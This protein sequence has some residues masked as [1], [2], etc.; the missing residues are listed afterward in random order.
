MTIT[1]RLRA[2]S[3]GAFALVAALPLASTPSRAA[4]HAD[5]PGTKADLAADITDIYAWADGNKVVASIGFAGLAEAGAPATYDPDVLYTIHV[6]RD[7]DNASDVDVLIQFG[8]DEA[9]D[10]GVRVRDLPGAVGDVIGPVD[11]VIEADLGLRVFAGLRGD[12]F[13]FDLD[14]FK[15]TTMTGDLSFDSTRDSF[16]GTNVTQ[17]VVEMAVDAVAQDSDSLQIW[18]STGRKEG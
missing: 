8:Q 5:A 17:I 16:A 4:D 9:G 6:D 13:F 11:T 15:M 2:V 10:W 7:G 14:G 12:A 3:S 18:A 1:R